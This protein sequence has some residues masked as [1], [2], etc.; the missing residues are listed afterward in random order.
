MVSQLWFDNPKARIE[1]G[2]N[3]MFKLDWLSPI[4][5]LDS[6]FMHRDEELRVGPVLLF[7]EDLKKAQGIELCLHNLWESLHI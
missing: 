2:K 1:L 3:G 6:V 5:N 4:L 7:W